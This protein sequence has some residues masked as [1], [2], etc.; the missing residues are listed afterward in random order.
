[1]NNEKT[2]KLLKSIRSKNCEEYDLFGNLVNTYNST[3]ELNKSSVSLAVNKKLLSSNNHLW[4]LSGDKDHLNMLL[5]HIYYKYDSNGNILN[6]STS[7]TKKFIES[8]E[9]SLYRKK[10][11]NTGRITPNGFYFQ[12]GDWK[13]F[14]CCPTNYSFKKFREEKYW[15]DSKR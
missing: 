12:Q 10:Y 9:L 8:T 1:M 5:D 6:A 3:H 15:K 2:R 4:C 14:L 13:N 7:F 11:L